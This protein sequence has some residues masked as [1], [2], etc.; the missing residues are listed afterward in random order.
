VAPDTPGLAPRRVLAPVRAGAF[1]LR[2]ASLS[3]T[4]VPL[5]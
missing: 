4:S 1:P 3:V 2:P 5:G